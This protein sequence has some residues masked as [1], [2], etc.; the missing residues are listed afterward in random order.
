MWLVSIFAYIQSSAII[1]GDLR[2]SV[3]EKTDYNQSVGNE[4]DPDST[5]FRFCIELLTLKLC[6]Y[7]KIHNALK[8]VFFFSFS[9]HYSAHFRISQFVRKK[10]K[11]NR[12][13]LTLCHSNRL[14]ES[15]ED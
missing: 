1:F 14:Q 10:E 4:V 13:L 6:H 5:S 2:L 3:V 15:C 8:D 9:I 12:G 11:I 7:W